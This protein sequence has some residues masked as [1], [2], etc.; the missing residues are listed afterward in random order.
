MK[1]PMR[2]KKIYQ[3]DDGRYIEVF[4]KVGEVDFQ[5]EK[6]EEVPEFS[7]DEKIYVGLIQIPVGPS[8]KEIKFEIAGVKTLEEAFDKFIGLA[9]PAAEQ[10]YKMLQEKMAQSQLVTSADPSILKKLD[11]QQQKGKIII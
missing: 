2:E 7:N 6:C 4:S 11:E 1:I 3:S 5:Q 8:L 10:F 9:Q